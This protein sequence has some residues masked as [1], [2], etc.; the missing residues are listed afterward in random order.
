MVL[1]EEVCT[2]E[3][4]WLAVKRHPALSASL[5]SATANSACPPPCTA[6]TTNRR[7]KSKRARAVRGVRINPKFGVN[8]TVLPVT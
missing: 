8:V 6:P 2:E 4:G 1:R 7:P 5:T 3:I